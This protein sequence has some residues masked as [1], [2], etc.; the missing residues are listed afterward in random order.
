MGND[1]AGGTSTDPN[2]D[3]A[4]KGLTEDDVGRIVNAAITSHI[5]RLDIGG[6]IKSALGELNLADTIKAEVAKVAPKPEPKGK[7]DDD[8]KGTVPPEIEQQLRNLTESLEAEKAAREAAEKSRADL[9]TQQQRSSAKSAF[10]DAVAEK[11]RPDLLPVFV[12]HFGDS[13][14]LLT[15]DEDGTPKLTVK[16]APYKGAPEEDVA[17]PLDQAVPILLAQKDVH[18]F[19]PAPGGQQGADGKAKTKPNLAPPT[20]PQGGDGDVNKAAIL[21]QE[22]EKRGLPL[23]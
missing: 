4:P 3:D 20:I 5:K 8:K 10:R 22:L 23:L 18:P 1:K 7:D 9:E 11:V 12:D 16:K 13:K 15:V 14:G 19:L 6:Q 17:L 21:A 2:P